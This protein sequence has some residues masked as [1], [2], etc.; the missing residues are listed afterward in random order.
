MHDQRKARGTCGAVKKANDH[1]DQDPSGRHASTFVRVQNCD[2]DRMFVNNA[3]RLQPRSG[4]EEMIMDQVL[5]L[6][7]TICGAEYAPDEA[8]YVCPRHG[9]DGTLDVFMITAGSNK[10]ISPA[11]LAANGDTPCGA[12]CPCF[13][14]TRIGAGR[15]VD[16][17]IM[18]SV[19][20]TPLIAAPASGGPT[21]SQAALGQGRRQA[22]HRFIQGS[23]LGHRR[24][25]NP[26][27][28]PQGR[29]NGQHRECGRRT[30]RAVRRR[31]P[32][33][34]D[35]CAAQRTAGQDCAAAGLS[36]P[37]CCWWMAPMMMPSSF[38]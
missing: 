11:E 35:F 9:N 24:G 7:C 3:G 36:A 8:A 2:F 32:A 12:T 26:R 33:Q 13:L 20:W 5:G 19:G 25:E 21:R 27:T 16:G 22:A 17:T 1:S 4:R 37:R 29:G 18:A 30:R 15:L 23:G 28:R 38:A 14:S 6:E 34:C 31:V 10:R